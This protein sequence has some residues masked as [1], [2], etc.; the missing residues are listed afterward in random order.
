MCVW[1]IDVCVT[2]AIPSICEV[3]LVFCVRES[4]NTCLASLQH[5]VRSLQLAVW[6]DILCFSWLLLCHH[7][8]DFLKITLDYTMDKVRK[9][10]WKNWWHNPESI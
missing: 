9:R 10:M 2:L 5:G 7:L 3:I 1:K 6:K 8:Q 4:F